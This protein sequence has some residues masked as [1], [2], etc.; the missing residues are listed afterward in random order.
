MRMGQ[1]IFQAQLKKN[2][3]VTAI[4]LA[5]AAA[6][7]LAGII[8]TL[9]ST[10]SNEAGCRVI[11]A[12][13]PVSGMRRG[14]YVKVESDSFV[15]TGIFYYQNNK[16]N[17]PTS[18]IYFVPIY[19]EEGLVEVVAVESRKNYQRDE[20][21]EPEARPMRTFKGLL[22]IDYDEDRQDNIEALMEI[23][24]DFT[25]EDAEFYL[26]EL[27]VGWN[28]PVTQPLW[29]LALLGTVL[30]SFNIGYARS[31]EKLRRRMEGYGVTQDAMQSFE[32]EYQQ[33]HEIF[34]K[35]EFT[36]HW[37]FSRA[38]GSTCL[39]PLGEVAWFYQ[40]VVRHYTNGI[41]SG[42][43]YTVELCFSDGGNLSLKSKRGDVG[44]MAEAIAAR[45]PQALTGFSK[46]REQAWKEDYMQI[47]KASR[48]VPAACV[49]PAETQAEQDAAAAGV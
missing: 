4:R 33:G 34:G 24:R 27:S 40:K 17:K 45:C 41:P 11:D 42:T 23:G 7:I 48:E 10:R 49:R 19:D 35:T 20:E 5:L 31:D 1:G 47:V 38:V 29:I 18:F 8:G 16:K 2:K 3:S 28:T 39:L 37:L 36:G 43:T 13:N 46:E 22:K 21:M 44:G 12:G 32:E 15:Y 14:D 25:R 9:I 26:P 6:M 30:F